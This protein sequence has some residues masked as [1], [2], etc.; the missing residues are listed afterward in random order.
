MIIF[1]IRIYKKINT[2]NTFVVNA[3]DGTYPL[4]VID[5][6]E[7]DISVL[8][9]NIYKIITSMKEQKEIL[10]GKF[11]YRFQTAKV[12]SSAPSKNSRILSAR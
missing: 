7:G 2:I 12:S 5:N 3:I 6:N 1:L 9:N 10:S 8:K 11:I 4:D